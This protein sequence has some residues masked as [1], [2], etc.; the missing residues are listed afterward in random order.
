MRNILL[1]LTFISSI[2]FAQ[3]G[4]NYQGAA[5]DAQ[6]NKLE[7][8]SI[9]LKTSI[10]QGGIE[11]SA[12]FSETHNTTT[13]Q[14]GLFNVVIG[15]G[16]VLTGS[17]DSIQW[18]ADAHYLKVELDATGGTDY[19]LV[20]TTQMMSV[21]YA[22]YAENAGIDSAMVADMIANSGMS[23]N[24][25]SF[26][27]PDGMNGTPITIAV[28][29]N[30]SFT[31][32]EGKNLYV[33]YFRQGGTS[34]L[35]I[36]EIRVA[37][38]YNN[39]NN[40][41]GADLLYVGEGQTI[42]CNNYEDINYWTTLNGI[43]TEKFVDLITLG[44]GE[45]SEGNSYTV[46]EG[47]NLYVNYFRPANFGDLYVD[48]IR[49][50]SGYNNYNNNRGAD[51]LYVGEGQTITC[52]NSNI[53][54]ENSTLNGYLA[55][56]DYFE[57]PSFNSADG[58]NFDETIDSLSQLVETLD[59]TLNVF[60][61]IFGC[62]DSTYCNFDVG[63]IHDDGSCNGIVGCT[64]PNAVNFN[65]LA[66]CD[67]NS[68]FLP[69][70]IGQSYQGG[71]VA[72]IDETGMHGLIASSED[73]GSYPFW[74]VDICYPTSMN[75]NYGSGDYNTTLASC[76]NYGNESAAYVCMQYNND[77]FNDWFLPSY[78]ELLI[79][80][81]NRSLIGGF[82]NNKYWSSTNNSGGCD[83]L[84]I[85]FSNGQQFGGPGIMYYRYVRPVRYF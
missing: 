38:N 25:K 34:D 29:T 67:D 10:L 59:S 4:I 74:C 16:D 18:G 77:G 48:D 69:L 57:I 27:Y 54:N 60:T 50:A 39:Y 73:I 30:N 47:K 20:S 22:K 72:Y 42:T 52:N 75:S 53:I 12:S 19:N 32:P 15:L 35:F 64:D 31:V 44:I 68:C 71:I 46:P 58:G 84:G 82:T 14:F 23:G 66:E 63:A 62:T 45:E 26:K 1:I 33:N 65:V 79:L 41:V 40:N 70:E 43:L 76:N 8:Q 11:G 13:D 28:G 80:Y 37:S 21:P 85:D 56:L 2:S 3:T 17:F 61:N 9:S 7:N 81:N 49:V 5:T 78:D 51:L 24:S 6:G 36:D 83:P 55:D